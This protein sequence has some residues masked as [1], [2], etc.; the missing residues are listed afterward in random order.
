MLDKWK[1][2]VDEDFEI[3]PLKSPKKAEMDMAKKLFG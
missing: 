1:S 3:Y 2:Y